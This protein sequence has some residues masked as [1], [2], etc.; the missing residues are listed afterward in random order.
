MSFINSLHN[1]HKKIIEKAERLETQVIIHFIYL[2]Y[3]LIYIKL[4]N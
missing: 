2:R 3:I 4:Q 1:I